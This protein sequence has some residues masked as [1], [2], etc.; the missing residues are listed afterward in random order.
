MKS[1]IF[2][3]E[4]SI[5]LIYLQ[6][7]IFP[8]KLFLVCGYFFYFRPSNISFHFLLASRFL[9]RNP[10]LGDSLV[11]EEFFTFL[12]LK[13]SFCL[14]FRHY[15]NVTW[16]RS[17]VETFCGS[18]SFMNLDVQISPRFGKF[19]LIISLSKL[20][21]SLSLSFPSETLRICKLF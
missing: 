2:C 11:C 6:R 14:D 12:L 15:Y 7:T 20:S 8:F 21:C 16:R 1:F 3:L 10:L 17:W 5:F 9:L 19:S 13:L 4:K 18:M